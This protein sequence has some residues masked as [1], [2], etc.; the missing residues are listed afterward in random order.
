VYRP[1]TPAAHRVGIADTVGIATPR[2]V[3]EMVVAVRAASAATS[4]FTATTTP[5]AR[6]PTPWPPWRPA[7]PTSTPPC[8]ASAS[9]TDR[10]PLRAHR[11]D[12]NV[13]PERSSSTASTS[14]PA[15]RPGRPHPRH[16]SALQRPITGAFAFTHKAGCTATRCSAIHAATRCSSPSVMAWIGRYSSAT[17]WSDATPSATA[18]EPRHR[19]RRGADRR[20]HRRDQAARRLRA[21][22]DEQWTHSCSAGASPPPSHTSG[23]F[24]PRWN[25][26]RRDTQPAVAGPSTPATRWLPSRR[27]DGHDVTGRSPSTPSQPG[28]ADLERLADHLQLR[29]RVPLKQRGASE[30][31]RAS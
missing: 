20:G 18:P 29:P 2:E 30:L 31:H 13:S 11:P 8:S 15:R 16:R 27:G 6:W 12:R 4:S 17:G 1:S 14:S 24:K 22:A 28:D 21:L 9:A 19:P 25:I 3:E 23:E 26:G 7:P 10:L 5:A